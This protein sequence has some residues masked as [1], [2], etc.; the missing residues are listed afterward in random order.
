MAAASLIYFDKS[1]HE[2]TIAEAAYLA[3][4]PKAPTQL[5]PFRQRDRAIERRNYVIDRMK[6][7]GYITA[8]DAETARKSPLTSRSAS[9]GAHVFA[10]EYFAEEVRREILDKYGEKKLYEG[11]LSVRATLDPKIQV[12]AR[13]AFTDGLINFDETQGYRGA[14]AKIDIAGDWGPKLADVRALSDVAPWRLAVVLDVNDQS[15]RIGFQPAREPGGAVVR[16]RQ[17]GNVPLDGV[18][19]AKAASGPGPQQGGRARHA[20]AG[21]GRRDLR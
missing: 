6:D 15:A 21:A 20:G 4:L 9:S 18:K 7:D 2:L 10:G 17:I 1:V 14:V 13:K 3:A 5:H 19:W 8:A 16:D 12:M 11:G